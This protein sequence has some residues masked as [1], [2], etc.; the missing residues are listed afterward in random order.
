MSENQEIQKIQITAS[1]GEVGGISLLFCIIG[2]IICIFGGFS[3]IGLKAA[4]DNSML[5]SI[6]N[7][8]GWYCL[9]KGIFMIAAPLH[10]REAFFKLIGQ[11]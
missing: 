10:A 6:A 5:E 2:G 9:G 3:L 4:S 8:I 1:T 11:K 7:G